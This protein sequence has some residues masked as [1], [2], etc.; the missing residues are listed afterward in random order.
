MMLITQTVTDHMSSMIESSSD[1]L[2][3]ICGIYELYEQ[4]SKDAGERRRMTGETAGI[5]AME[6]DFVDNLSLI[7]AAGNIVSQVREQK[8]KKQLFRTKY[9]EEVMLSVYEDGEG[10]TFLA[11]DRELKN[12]SRVELVVDLKRYYEQLISTIR[13]GSNGYLL[14]KTSD[15]TIIMHPAKEQLGIDVIEGRKEMFAGLDLRDLEQM[16]DKQ[17][18]G[19]EG[20]SVYHSYWW[21]DESLPRVKKIAAYTPLNFLNDFFIIS[22]VI[23]YDDISV[24]VEEGVVRISMMLLIVFLSVLA[25]MSALYFILKGRAEAQEEIAYLKELNSTLEEMHRSEDRI[26]HQQRLQIIGT[27]TSGIA[28]EFNNLLTPIMGYAGMMLEEMDK[29]DENY[30]D[31]KEIYDASEKAKEIILQISALSRKNM[32]TTFKHITAKSLLIR[33]MKMIRSICPDNITVE[34]ELDL[35][36]Q[37]FL[38]NETQMNQMM[39]NLCVNG[40]HAV[41][42][43]EGRLKVQA[44]V[45]NT[46]ILKRDHP[47]L[48]PDEI[49]EEFVRIRIRDTGSGM[50]PEVASQIFNPFFTTKQTGQGTGLGLTI[51][52]N[53]V[54]SHKGL[55]AVNS[56]EGVGTTF[57]V[58]LPVNQEA[59]LELSKPEAIHDISGLSLLILDNNPKV[60]RL[61][62]RGFKKMDLTVDTCSNTKEVLNMLRKKHY[63]FFMTDYYMSG[64][65]GL[66]VAM[67]ARGIWPDIRIIMATS[68]LRK[69]II[70]AKKDKVINSYIEKP[71]ACQQILKIMYEIEKSNIR[72]GAPDKAAP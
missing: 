30:Q 39:L 5:A 16:I 33:S 72:P 60:L 71:V 10:Y 38:G 48:I 55:I 49:F 35:G 66:S 57:T 31:V 36:K 26:A 62:E 28:H 34:E 54:V 13:M 29:E 42:R 43:D 22:S 7:D 64:T 40:F 9:S 56:K 17:K 24:P 46:G 2:S 32:E 25:L 37:G 23:D 50:T 8:F 44:D 20:I 67:A 12:G 19:E 58:C 14:A 18:K 3:I 11:L 15:G 41:G 61:L 4:N 65:S 53:I 1:D 59:E 27:M 21:T 69:E 63:D 45:V 47:G 52:D 70:E 68:I 51:V 6:K